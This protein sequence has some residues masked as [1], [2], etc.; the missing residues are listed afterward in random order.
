LPV[1][2]LSHCVGLI[3][4]DTNNTK[5]KCVVC[6]EDEGSV[7][8]DVIR[9]GKHGFEVNNMRKIQ[10]ELI[11]R[12]RF[13]FGMT[14]VAVNAF[15]IVGG[16][17]SDEMLIITAICTAKDVS[18]KVTKIQTKLPKIISGNSI[19]MDWNACIHCIGGEDNSFNPL[20]AHYKWEVLSNPFA[21]VCEFNPGFP[22]CQRRVFRLNLRYLLP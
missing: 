14:P 16:S 22:L 4:C 6:F 12:G 7:L 17:S 5:Q 3:E 11:P 18:F 2:M 13:W 15:L 1:E 20:N 9:T 19:V 21:K 8:F 10:T